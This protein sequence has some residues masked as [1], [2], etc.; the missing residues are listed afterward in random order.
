MQLTKSLQ[1]NQTKLKKYIESEKIEC[2]RIL[3]PTTNFPFAID[4]YLDRVLIYFYEEI[5]LEEKEKI[6]FEVQNF[7]Q[8]SKN[9][10]YTKERKKQKEGTQYEKLDSTKENFVIRENDYLVYV[11]L[12]D[13]LDTGIFLDHRKSRKFIKEELAPKSRSVLNLFS[14]TSSFSI[15]ASFGGSEFTTS[16]DM[17]NTYLEW[18]E[19]NFILNKMDLKKNKLIRE[20]ILE[21]FQFL[22]KD[23][24]FDL[25]IIDPP[26]FSRSKKMKIPFD[27]QKD[28][29]YLLNQSLKKLNPRG[30]IFFSTN[31][32]KFKLNSEQIPNSKITEITNET[33]P[34][35]FLDTKIHKSF[36][37]SKDSL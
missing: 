15:A 36:L 37:I 18:S 32:Q 25:I 31:F 14:Y 27:I 13:Y 26:T 6:I 17:S 9:L 21:Y 24:M 20:N 11:N 29:A 5:L 3:N 16:V 19:E 10:I 35:D 4:K 1:E 30:K 12:K 8:I 22:K 34:D 28:Y 33:I 7:F 2:Y 23:K